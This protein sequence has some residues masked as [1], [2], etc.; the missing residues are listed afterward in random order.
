[1]LCSAIIKAEL[2]ISV[3]SGWFGVTSYV[4]EISFTVFKM[5]SPPDKGGT[6][7]SEI[8][9]RKTRSQTKEETNDNKKGDEDTENEL[10]KTNEEV[11][12]QPASESGVENPRPPIPPQEAATQGFPQQPLQPQTTYQDVL[13]VPPNRI[14]FAVPKW[15]VFTAIAIIGIIFVSLGG[16]FGD[17]IYKAYFLP[18]QMMPNMTFSSV[19]KDGWEF[20]KKYDRDG[21]YKLSLDEYEAI[22]H[23]LVANGINVSLH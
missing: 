21:D 6:G 18:G 22:Y 13:V 20:F 17:K 12:N 16:F 11:K 23:T 4:T 15:M 8:R 10:T 7:D 2:A 19:G 5:S 1:M 14:I 3:I 9:R